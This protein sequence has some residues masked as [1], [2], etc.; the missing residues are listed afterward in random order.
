MNKVGITIN[1]PKQRITKAATTSGT[2]DQL[3]HVLKELT[4]DYYSSSSNGL[5]FTKY[6]RI[7]SFERK[8]FYS[9]IKH[10]IG[11]KLQ[12]I[13]M[14]QFLKKHDIMDTV[15]D[16]LDHGKHSIEHKGFGLSL[17]VVVGIGM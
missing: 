5:Y 11:K 8:H 6:E 12:K 17:Y 7:S 15:D 3:S 14:N 4:L 9:K 1:A 13:T 2:R 10:E 16:I